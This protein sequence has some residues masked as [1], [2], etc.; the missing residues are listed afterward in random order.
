MGGLNRLRLA[1]ELVALTVLGGVRRRV[2]W[3]GS[4]EPFER[5]R[6]RLVVEEVFVS[7]DRFRRRGLPFVEGVFDAVADLEPLRDR[8]CERL[9]LFE[10]TVPPRIC[11]LCLHCVQD[12]MFQPVFRSKQDPTGG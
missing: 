8:F 1:F 7:E 5:L 4:D 6:C 12:S 3:A 11:Q 10:L 9:S 2:L